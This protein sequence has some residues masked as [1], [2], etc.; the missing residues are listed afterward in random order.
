MSDRL[1]PGPGAIQH[2]QDFD[3]DFIDLVAGKHRPTDPAHSG[4]DVFQR[5][6]AG[7]RGNRAA[8]S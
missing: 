6:K 7:R 2:A 3:L 8:S 1:G 5:E 4:L